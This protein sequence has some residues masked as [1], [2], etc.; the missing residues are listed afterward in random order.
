MQQHQRLGIVTTNRN[1][2][3]KKIA[4]DAMMFL[5]WRLLKMEKLAGFFVYSPFDL[6]IR[7]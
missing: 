5:G 6:R 1:K 4:S 7:R 2:S 3:D